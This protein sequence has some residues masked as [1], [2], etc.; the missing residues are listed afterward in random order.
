MEFIK[1]DLQ[2]FADTVTVS[3]PKE[4]RDA[5]SS[6]TGTTTIQ[7][8]QNL[9]MTNTEDPSQ[10]ALGEPPHDYYCAKLETSGADVTV[11][12]N[13]FSIRDECASGSHG[14]FFRYHKERLLLRTVR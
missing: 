9:V 14:V 13:G 4:L 5:L 3:T 2:I 12:L 6:A 11:D 10:Y 7:L 1:F 8:T